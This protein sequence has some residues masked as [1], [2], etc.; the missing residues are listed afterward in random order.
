[1]IKGTV[2]FNM[3]RVVERAGTA[4]TREDSRDCNMLQKREPVSSL[5]PW[6]CW[7]WSLVDLAV[8]GLQL[9]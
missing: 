2:A 7:T 4:Q 8:L 3:R 6:R 5:H 1:M 9:D